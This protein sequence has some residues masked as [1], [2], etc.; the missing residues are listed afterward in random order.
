[1]IF[2][3]SQKFL[4]RILLLEM[5]YT[6]NIIPIIFLNTLPPRVSEISIIS[7]LGKFLRSLHIKYEIIIAIILT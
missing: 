4:R 1:M 6:I 5:K 2:K 7:K 3:H